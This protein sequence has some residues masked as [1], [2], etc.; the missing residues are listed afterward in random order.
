MYF[1][2]KNEDVPL[3]KLRVFP[4][5]CSRF[6]LCNELVYVK[7]VGPFREDPPFSV[8]TSDSKDS[9]RQMSVTN[10]RK[11][12]CAMRYS[13]KEV[14]EYVKEAN[15]KFIRLAFCDVFGVQKNIAI[16][17]S[18]LNRAFET[19]IAIDAS[20][21]AGFGGAIRSDLFLHPDSSTLVHLPW[22]PETGG[23]VR[24]FCDVTYPD[25][26][27]L[28]VD[29]RSILKN[30][31]SAAEQAGVT[32]AFG[33]EMEFYLFKTD[34]N[35][36][37]TLQPYDNAGYMDIA[38]DDK[39]ENV[40]RAICMTLEQMGIQPESSH[41]EEGPGQNEIDF[42]YSDP[43]SAA[44]NAVTFKSVVKSV[45]MQ[46]GLFADFSPKPLPDHAGSGLHINISV[47]SQDHQDL[48]PHVIAGIMEHIADI[49]LF[50]NPCEQS[51]ERLGKNK[52]PGYI[53]WSSE[54][55]SQLIRIPAADTEHRRAEL[56]S[57]DP[58][59]NPYLAFALLIFAGLD[60]IAKKLLPPASTDINLYAAP[61][62]VLAAYKRLPSSLQE[63]RCTAS[64]SDFIRAHLPDT[65]IESYC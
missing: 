30:A 59:A 8:V 36:D 42:R 21:I 25:G 39:G 50:T 11:A 18:E 12:G 56:R 62:D 19:G 20:A 15:V 34:E 51:Y 60:G 2:D 47:K 49:T 4:P 6:F 9:Y 65:V 61:A 53:T 37:P 38:P 45:A 43:L 48:L 7:T 35:G 41:H 54:N 23:V 28:E 1:I 26:R 14:M 29:T 24:M 3:E 22:R 46:N 33:A 57:A 16:M 13:P 58:A 40:R 10:E 32:F 27:K 5:E 55:R 64:T 63:A 52:A 31:I 44:D 17:P